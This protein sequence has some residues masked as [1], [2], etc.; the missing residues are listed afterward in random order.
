MN[1]GFILNGLVMLVLKTTAACWPTL[2]HKKNYKEK[3]SLGSA[4]LERL[5]LV[6]KMV[7]R[8]KDT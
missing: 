8:R 1:E 2:R 3:T 5:P 4:H 6:H 7:K